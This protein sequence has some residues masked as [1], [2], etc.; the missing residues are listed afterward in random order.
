MLP[1]PVVSLV[2]IPALAAAAAGGV[3]CRN[4]CMWLGEAQINKMW[5]RHDGDFEGQ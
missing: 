4:G 3:L 1:S 5:S 2:G